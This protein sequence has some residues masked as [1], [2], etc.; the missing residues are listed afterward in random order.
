[1]LAGGGGVKNNVVR[2]RI[3]GIVNS[4]NLRYDR[5]NQIWF[6][7]STKEQCYT[8]NYLTD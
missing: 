2:R 8:L 3:E 6:Q 1:M 4:S 5:I 7:V